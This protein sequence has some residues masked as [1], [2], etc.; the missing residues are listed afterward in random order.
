MPFDPS[1]RAEPRLLGAQFLVCVGAWV[2][3]DLGIAGTIN[4][5]GLAAS[6]ATGVILVAVSWMLVKLGWDHGPS[7]P[8]NRLVGNERTA[9]G[10]ERSS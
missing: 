3:I 10:G 7:R 5:T 4:G 8:N 1:R 2:A 9:D 6:V